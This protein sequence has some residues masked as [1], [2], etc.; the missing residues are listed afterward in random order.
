MDPDTA[1]RHPV[2]PDA[3]LRKAR[4]IDAG[5]KQSGCLG[6]QLVPAKKERFQIRV[7]MN[8]EVL[9]RGEHHFL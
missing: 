7:G 9:D 1:E 3:F 6:M 4:A 8:V 2:E 5:N